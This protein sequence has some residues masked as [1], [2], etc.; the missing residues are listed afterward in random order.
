[1]T[2]QSFLEFRKKQAAAHEANVAGSDDPMASLISVEINLMD[3]CNRTCSFCPHADPEIYPNRYDMKMSVATSETLAA[4]LAAID[5]KGRVSMSGYGEPMLLRNV[6]RHIE[7][8]RQALPDNVIEM[9]T[10]G[11]ALSPDRI[12][13]LF[14][15][16]LSQVY[17]NLYDGPQQADIIKQMFADAG[18]DRYVLREHWL[19][20]ENFGLVVNNRS[21]VVNPIAEPMRKR[22][23][24]PFYKLFVD[25]NGDVLF[26]ANDWGRNIVVGSIHEFPVDGIWMSE[27][28]KEIRLRLADGD[29]SHAPCNTCDVDGTLHSQFS[30]DMLMDHYRRTPG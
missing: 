22:C 5:Y 24:Y 28:M 11:D 8:Y 23:H 29:R 15:A 2:G 4:Q 7:I 27:K 18:T 12:R 30:F 6:Y 16:G 1:M 19:A 20:E 3:A 9:N 14:E 21:G 13:R 25:W 17:V 10:N 26:C